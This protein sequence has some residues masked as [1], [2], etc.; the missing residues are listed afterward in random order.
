MCLWSNIW[1]VVGAWLEKWHEQVEHWGKEEDV[2]TGHFK[3]F[4]KEQIKEVGPTIDRVELPVGTLGRKLKE[5]WPV[6]K[7]SRIF[8][9]LGFQA[10]CGDVVISLVQ[11]PSKDNIPKT[12]PDVWENYVLM[13]TDKLYHTDN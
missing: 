6:E 3:S 5:S 1:E 10:K 7:K 11:V 8:S 4:S 2:K 13:M 12:Q 9:Y